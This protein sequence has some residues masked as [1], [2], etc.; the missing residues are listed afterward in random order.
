MIEDENYSL[1]NILEA[2][3][4]C[5]LH[6]YRL[7]TVSS[8]YDDLAFKYYHI[9]KTPS[10]SVLPFLMYLNYKYPR[11]ENIGYYIEV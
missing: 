1:K 7:D 6:L 8:P 5:G 3:N 11:H 9:F 10:Q 2:A 4:I